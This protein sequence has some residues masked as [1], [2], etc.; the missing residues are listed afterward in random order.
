VCWARILELGLVAQTLLSP[1]F[2]S[3]CAVAVMQLVSLLHRINT[4]GTWDPRK[5]FALQKIPDPGIVHK[6]CSVLV[7]VL[8][9]YSHENST[10]RT[11]FHL[12]PNT[13]IIYDL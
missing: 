3:A 11:S 7:L 4:G 2:G 5:K 9:F 12:N 10:V 13:I 8:R 6:Q 1:L